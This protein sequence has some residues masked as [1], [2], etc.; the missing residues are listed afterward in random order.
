MATTAQ[1]YG[2]HLLVFP[3]PS[4]GHIIPVLDLTRLLFARGLHITVLVTPTYLPLL[5]PLLTSHPSSSIQSLVLSLPKPSISSQSNIFAKMSKL[6]ELR[7]PILQWFQSHPA[8]PVAIISDFFLGWIHDLASQLKVPRV[9]FWPSGAFASLVLNYL[10]RDLPRNDHPDDDNVLISLPKIPNSPKFPWWQLSRLYRACKEGDPDCEFFRNGMLANFASWAVVFNS[11][12]NLEEIYI[13]HFKE[14]VMGHDRVCR[15]V[16]EDD[17]MEALAT[18]LECSGVHFI[19]CVKTSDEELVANESGGAILDEFED[20]VKDRGFVIRG[21]APQLEILRHRAVGTFL[22][23]CGW[24]S[25]LE[26]LNSGVMMLAWPMGADQF[27]NAMLLVDQLGVA[28]RVCA[29]G[30]KVVPNSTELARLFIDSVSGARPERA[31]VMQ[32]QEE[33]SKAVLVKGGSSHRELDELV[34]RLSELH[35]GRHYD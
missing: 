18:A 15:C 10:W 29:G 8:P 20:R 9:V 13:D 21:W 33:A 4:S 23:H 2:A 30:E 25:V 35:S 3:F 16:L 19:W 26:G 27:C 12:T 17:Q 5:E 34:K 6:H 32:L 1:S 31:I 24:N 14:K 11:F 22:T 28:I 7:D